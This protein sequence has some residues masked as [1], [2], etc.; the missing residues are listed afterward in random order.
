MKKWLALLLAAVMSL[1]AGSALHWR[2][3][4]PNEFPIVN[5]PVTLK[6]L[7]T[8]SLNVEDSGYERTD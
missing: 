5:E 1:T 6:V 8:M 4:P 7:T 3:R 2:C